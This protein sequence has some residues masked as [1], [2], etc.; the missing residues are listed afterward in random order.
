MYAYFS[1]D[2]LAAMKYQRLARDG[3]LATY[4]HANVPVYLQLQDEIGFP[5]EGSIDFANNSF[6][7]STGTILIRGSFPNHDGFLTPGAFVRVRVASSAKFEALLVADRAIGSD[8]GQSYVYV[9]DSK[10]VVAMRRITTGQIVDGLRV[11][12]SGLNADDVVII[13]GTLK[14]RPGNPVKPIK[15]SMEQFTSN[16]TSLSVSTVKESPSP[17]GTSRDQKAELAKTWRAMKL[18]HFFIGRPIFA[19]VVS[20]VIVLL[21]GIAY[22]TLPVAQYPDVTPPTV[23]VT[24][25]YGAELPKDCSTRS[26]PMDRMEQCATSPSTSE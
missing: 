23:Q 18:S 22:F 4:Q 2:E 14:A 15:G 24:T 26:R 12:T 9:I 10:N 25:T 7:S 21:G 20:T 6:D 17:G 5:H 11:V 13:N 8:Q 16:D 1:V 3:K 19:I